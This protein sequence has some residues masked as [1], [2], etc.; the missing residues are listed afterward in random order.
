MIP[1]AAEPFMANGMA[2]GELAAILLSLHSKQRAL[3]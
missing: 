1:E 3:Q 2:M